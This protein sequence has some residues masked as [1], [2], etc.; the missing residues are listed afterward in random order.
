MKMLG[1]TPEKIVGESVVMWEDPMEVI[2]V[3]EDFHYESAAKDIRPL[4][5]T[6]YSDRIRNIPVRIAPQ[7]DRVETLA[8]INRTMKLFDQDYIML[9]EFASDIYNR[10]YKSRY[11][12]CLSF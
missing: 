7:A 3:I 6:A 8:R 11:K 9:H 1:S 2:G 10:Y 5:M 4:M 12:Y